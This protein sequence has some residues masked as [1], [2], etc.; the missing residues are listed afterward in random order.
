MKNFTFTISDKL[1]IHARPAGMIVKM[2]KES[3]AKVTISKDGNDVDASKL[4]ALMGMGIKYSDTIKLS[5]S[6]DN[7]NETFEKL[8]AFFEEIL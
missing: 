5:V 6:G 1:G 8:K 7:E 2:V 3:G 4:M